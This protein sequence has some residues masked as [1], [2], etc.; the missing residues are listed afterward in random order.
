MAEY[1]SKGLYELEEQARRQQESRNQRYL[2]EQEDRINE[3][4]EYADRLQE[5]NEEASERL[6]E[7]QKAAADE[8]EAYFDEQVSYLEEQAAAK[9]S[10]LREAELRRAQAQ[11]RAAAQRAQEQKERQ[12]QRSQAEKIRQNRINASRSKGWT[13][14]RARGTSPAGRTGAQA[15]ANAALS[16]AESQMSRLNGG[17]RL[18]SLSGHSVSVSDDGTFTA[19][20]TMPVGNEQDMR[21]WLMA[22]LADIDDLDIEEIPTEYAETPTSGMSAKALAALKSSYL[23]KTGQAPLLDENGNITAPSNS[24]L[25]SDMGTAALAGQQSEDSGRYR[26]IERMKRMRL[27]RRNRAL[28]MG[29]D[30][31]TLDYRVPEGEEDEDG[32]YKDLADAQNK[33]LKEDRVKS[34]AGAVHRAIRTV[35]VTLAAIFGVVKTIAGL[36]KKGA[37]EAYK[38][39]VTAVKLNLSPMQVERYNAYDESLGLKSGT[40]TGAMENL[41]KTFNQPEDLSNKTVIQ[42]LALLGTGT[43]EENL[44]G[45]AIDVATNAGSV[46]PVHQAVIRAAEERISRKIDLNGKSYKTE[47]EA[48]RAVSNALANGGL[49]QESEI[50][51]ARRQRAENPY[52]NNM[53]TNPVMLVTLSDLLN[54]AAGK[55][56]IGTIESLLTQIRELIASWAN[57]SGLLDNLYALLVKKFGDAQAKA[58]VAAQNQAVSQNRRK[59]YLA[60]AAAIQKNLSAAAGADIR[61]LGDAFGDDYMNGPEFTLSDGEGNLYKQSIQGMFKTLGEGADIPSFAVSALFSAMNQEAKHGSSKTKDFYADAKKRL[62]NLWFQ[63]MY[64]NAYKDEAARYDPDAYYLSVGTDYDVQKRAMDV[65]ASAANKSIMREGTSVSGGTGTVSAGDTSVT[66]D[67]TVNGEDEAAQKVLQDEFVKRFITPFVTLADSNAPQTNVTLNVT[68]DDDKGVKRTV[69]QTFSAAAE[70]G[71]KAGLN[72]FNAPPGGLGGGK[73]VIGTTTVKASGSVWSKGK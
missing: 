27:D 32:S 8:Q 10:L 40:T 5:Q 36:I 64:A 67:A 73:A 16:G 66:Y 51:L 41:L 42:T 17:S 14:M 31:N 30:E 45:N 72:L 19:D 44:L 11:Q 6:F 38:T 59:N 63:N 22:G 26:N 52:D 23:K 71:A 54:A 56:K 3:Q 1:D 24:R 34:S 69:T 48:A 43:K 33:Q 35:V 15:S 60:S 13:T 4:A 29:V 37:D 55:G 9:Q 46:E 2:D 20:L 28:G 21:G 62:Y 12:E 70:A 57:K 49:A 18:R 68:V 47:G 53:R 7:A 65:F 39:A 58:E 61:T 50:V 25:S